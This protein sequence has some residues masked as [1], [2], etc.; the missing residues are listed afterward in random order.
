MREKKQLGET[1]K[2]RSRDVELTE[3]MFLL[4]ILTYY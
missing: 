3:G 1:R 4:F 2:K